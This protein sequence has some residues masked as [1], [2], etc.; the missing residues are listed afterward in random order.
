MPNL[1][2]AGPGSGSPVVRRPVAVVRFGIGLLAVS[3]VTVAVVL[4]LCATV[5]PAVVGWRSVAIVSGSMRPAID[6]GDVIVAEPYRGQELQPGCVLVFHDPGG[7]GLVSHRLHAVNDDGTLVTW[8]DANGEPDSTP[9]RPE[10]VVGVGRI[11]VPWVGAPSVWA[12]AHDVGALVLASIAALA[13]LHMARWGMLLR[14]DPWQS[15]RDGPDSAT[16]G[17]ERV[18]DGDRETDAGFDWPAFDAA[19]S[20]HF[21]ARHRAEFAAA[22]VW[23]AT[24]LGELTTSGGRRTPAHHA[25]SDVL[26]PE[27]LIRVVRATDPVDHRHLADATG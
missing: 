8:G 11:L 26:A 19:E 10:S 3:A 16:P 5:L 12:G 20:R 9:I 18:A 2:A 7:S 6:V 21:A 25:P 27:G 1:I 15:R 4:V 23:L 22:Q 24:E 14:F 17:P 13:V